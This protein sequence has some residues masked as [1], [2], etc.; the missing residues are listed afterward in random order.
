MLDSIGAQLADWKYGREIVK[1]F[2]TLLNDSDLDKILPRKN[3][4]TI[5]KQCEELIQVQTCY[6]EALETKQIKFVYESLSDISKSGLIERMNLLD[7]TMEI[8]FDQFDGN[9]KIVWFGEE[10][11]IHQHI[12]AMIGHEQMHVGQIIAFCYSC[13][14]CIPE[15]I[16]QKM[17]LNG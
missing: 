10:W 7:S 11:N 4:N 12:S 14:I 5:R 9:E 3:L 15:N 2:I 16:V 1:N 13:D 8:Q 17:S 6:V